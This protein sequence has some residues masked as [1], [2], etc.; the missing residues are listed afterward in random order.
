VEVAVFGVGVG[1]G[2]DT[3]L[4]WDERGRAEPG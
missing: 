2:V 1:V 3:D 4:L